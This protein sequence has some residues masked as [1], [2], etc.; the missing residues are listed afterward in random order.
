VGHQLPRTCAV[1]QQGY[2]KQTLLV[3]PVL[4]TCSI[5]TANQAPNKQCQLSSCLQVVVCEM[6]AGLSGWAG[7]DNVMLSSAVL[8]VMWCAVMCCSWPGGRERPGRHPAGCRCL[9]RAHA[10]SQEG[11]ALQHHHIRGRCL[12]THSMLVQQQRRHLQLQCQQP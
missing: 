2:L 6:P 11:G 3:L 10:G 4:E 5:G 1:Q 8:L 12:L 9:R 7:L